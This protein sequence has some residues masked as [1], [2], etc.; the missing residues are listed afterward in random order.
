MFSEGQE[1][2]KRDSVT[3]LQT[4]SR[5][6]RVYRYIVGTSRGQSHFSRK[7]I[8]I[9]SLLSRSRIALG[10][11]TS[12]PFR[13]SVTLINIQRITIAISSHICLPDSS[14]QFHIPYDSVAIRQ[15]DDPTIQSDPIRFDSIQCDP[16]KS[17]AHHI[18]IF[19][20]ILTQLNPSKLPAPLI[21]NVMRQLN[22]LSSALCRFSCCCCCCCWST[23]AIR[24]H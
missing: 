17:P 13:L 7:L 9:L 22:C 2:K 20:L 19:M 14:K 8:V 18:R 23:H 6:Y 12:Q 3:V 5:W 15:S 16:L 11:T 21:R 4:T 10:A 1:E 24:S